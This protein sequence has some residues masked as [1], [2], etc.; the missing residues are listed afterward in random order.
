MAYLEDLSAAK[1]KEMV[2][3]ALEFAL[4]DLKGPAPTWELVKLI[5]A[6]LHTN[7]QKLCARIVSSLAPA[8]PKAHRGAPFKRFGRTMTHWQWG[9]AAKPANDTEWEIVTQAGP[10]P[11]DERDAAGQLT[12]AA[13]ALRV[14]RDLEEV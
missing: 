12:P 5:C 14:A 7:E 9:P 10:D 1:R 3:I 4:A 8:H 2:G 6:R 11:A 13:R